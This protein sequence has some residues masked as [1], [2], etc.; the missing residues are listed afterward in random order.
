MGK[1]KFKNLSEKEKELIKLLIKK[2]DLKQNE[3]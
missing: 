3:R 2:L 1:K